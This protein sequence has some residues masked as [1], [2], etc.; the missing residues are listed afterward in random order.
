M[1]SAIDALGNS[2]FA[3]TVPVDSIVSK[4]QEE[5]DKARSE[6]QDKIDVK[7]SSLGEISRLQSAIVKIKAAAGSIADPLQTGFGSKTATVTT[8][9]AGLSGSG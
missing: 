1:A 3:G 4:F 8:S 6:I 2:L 9:E 7:E 5:G